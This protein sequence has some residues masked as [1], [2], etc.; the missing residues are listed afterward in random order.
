GI[1]PVFRVQTALGRE[2]EVTLT[3]PFLTVEGWRPLGELNVG[4]RVAVPRVIPV[5][6][7]DDVPVHEAK[8]LGYLLADGGLTGAN[9]QFANRNPCLQED[10]ASAA[11]QFSGIKVCIR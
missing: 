5:F 11:L 6:G 2:I 1:K 7:N 10:F 9:P 8:I 4:D 3:H